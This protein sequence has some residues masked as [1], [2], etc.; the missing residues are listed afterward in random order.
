M[1]MVS[2]TET[3]NNSNIGFTHEDFAALL[4]QYDY[5]FSPGDIV[6][7]TVFSMEPRGL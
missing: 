5:H 6:A 3:L 2:Q 7:G 4:D 1:P